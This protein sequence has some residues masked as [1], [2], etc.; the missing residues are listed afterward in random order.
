[1]QR[2]FA[3][4]WL[5][6]ALALLPALSGCERREPLTAAAC[7]KAIIDAK[8]ERSATGCLTFEL[9]SEA[10]V[11]VNGEAPSGDA[12]PE[13]MLMPLGDHRVEVLARGY[14]AW[15]GA[16][17]LEAGKLTVVAPEL[18]ETG[19]RKAAYALSIV[20]GVLSVVRYRESRDLAQTADFSDE[21]TKTEYA[22]LVSASEDFRLGSG[23]AGGAGLGLFALGA[24]LFVFDQPQSQD[25]QATG[26]QLTLRAAF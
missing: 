4:S 21:A 13:L 22:S 15:I 24:S 26:G 10:T 6:L 11:R 8:L 16:L 14:E 23:V 17:E 7:E 1:M 9:P 3:P 2:S 5:S 18:E 25:A 19:Q 20:L 12:P